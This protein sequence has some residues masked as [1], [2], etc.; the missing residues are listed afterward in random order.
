MRAV[1]FAAA[2]SMS[3]AATAAPRAASMQA[4][5]RPMPEPAPVTTAML[6]SDAIADLLRRFWS[7]AI[8]NQERRPGATTVCAILR[9][10]E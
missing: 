4:L 3:I 5:A 1:S 7:C 10:F 6:F 9:Q 8:R 2:S